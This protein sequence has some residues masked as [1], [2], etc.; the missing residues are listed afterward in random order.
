MELT[1][2][3]PAVAQTQLDS[4]VSLIARD[5]TGAIVA[6]ELVDAAGDVLDA[7][8]TERALGNYRTNAN[9][10]ADRALDDLIAHLELRAA[11]GE[12]LNFAE[13]SRS[14]G[15]SRQTLYTRLSGHARAR[16]SA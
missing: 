4:L 2:E 12:R 15:L 5:L 9:R 16:A 10:L 8:H 7:E 11:A 14:T 1:V 3:H 13:I 6:A